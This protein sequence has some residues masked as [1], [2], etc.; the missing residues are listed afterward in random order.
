MEPSALRLIIASKLAEGR[1]PFKIIP[2][3]SGGAGYGQMCNA[4]DEPITKEHMGLEEMGLG[5]NALHFHV[6][7]FNVWDELCRSASE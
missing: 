2:R 6:R 7:C 3:I 4:C 1:V 5:Q